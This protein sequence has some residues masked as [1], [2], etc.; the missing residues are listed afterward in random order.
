[1][2][3]VQLLVRRVR[4]L[5]ARYRRPL[6]AALAAVAVVALIQTLSPAAPATRH[7]AVAA[8]DL[9]AGVVLAPADVRVVSMPPDVVPAGSPSST[10]PVLGR[11]VAGPLRAGEALTD[12]R[13]LGRSL[14]AGYSPG[15]VAAPI[16]IGD[17]AVVDLLTVGDRIDVYAARRDTTLAERV[18]A[19]ARVVT[20]PRPVSDNEQGALVVLA[21]TPEQAAALAQ[22]SVTAPLSLTLLR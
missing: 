5:L 12:R 7:V 21:V 15:L 22:A 4:R 2:R 18:V 3:D 6:S 1:M 19:D 20:L 9:A 14:L 10:D 17:A 11:V 8:R 16:R 13:V